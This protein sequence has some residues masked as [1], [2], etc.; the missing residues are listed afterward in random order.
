MDTS[1]KNR[2]IGMLVFGGYAAKDQHAVRFL[3]E[4]SI[5]VAVM[6]QPQDRLL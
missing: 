3:S 6:P 2:T 1:D 5:T 4:L